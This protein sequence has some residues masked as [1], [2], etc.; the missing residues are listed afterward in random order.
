MFQFANV[1]LV[2]YKC[3]HNIQ[4]KAAYLWFIYIVPEMLLIS[5][6]I[7]KDTL[8]RHELEVLQ[9]SIFSLQFEVGVHRKE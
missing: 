2:S 4:G 9:L 7:D 8:A 6:L 5:I 1:H 3:G